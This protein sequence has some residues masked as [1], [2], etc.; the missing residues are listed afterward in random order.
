MTITLNDKEEALLEEL[1]DNAFRDKAGY[2]S[3]EFSMPYEQA[4]ALR[5][6]LRANDPVPNLGDG[7]PL[8]PEVIK[9][10]TEGIRAKLAGKARETNPYAPAGNGLRTRGWYSG[11]DG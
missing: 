7:T 4:Q 3:F 1:L 10:V 5:E 6:K 8:T 2:D 11:Y 9:A